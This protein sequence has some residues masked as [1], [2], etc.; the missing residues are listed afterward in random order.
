MSLKSMEVSYFGS[1]S[2]KSSTSGLFSKNLSI[3]A[4]TKILAD[5]WI[6]SDFHNVLKDDD[7][8]DYQFQLICF[9]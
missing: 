3:L 6:S 8:G 2:G 9:G 1:S 4:L 7:E 5:I